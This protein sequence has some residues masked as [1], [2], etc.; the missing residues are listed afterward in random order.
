MKMPNHGV[1]LF[2][3]ALLYG[4]T[5][6][7]ET[8]PII[9]QKLQYKKKH[10]EVVEGVTFVDQPGESSNVLL[11]KEDDSALSDYIDPKLA[12]S[13]HSIF[14]G[15]STFVQTE[16]KDDKA[17]EPEK[18]E[19]LDPKIAKSHTTF[20]PQKKD[21]KAGEPEKVEVLDPKI[22]KEHTTFYPK[23]NKKNGTAV[24]QAKK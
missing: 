24:A 20:Y 21:D 15:V 1:K 19:V 3:E 2:A 8:G 10:H 9:P 17:G 5:E 13:F 14:P 6:G 16:K 23:D 12:G 22:A 18:V 11:N 7:E 4:D